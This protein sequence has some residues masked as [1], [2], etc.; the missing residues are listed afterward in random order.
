MIAQ[1]RQGFLG[2]KLTV[3]VDGCGYSC[4]S[5]LH[6]GILAQTQC[7]KSTHFACYRIGLAYHGLGPGQKP[8]GL[9]GPYKISTVGP[10]ET[11]VPGLPG[12]KVNGH[13]S[14]AVGPI[15]TIRLRLWAL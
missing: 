11:M 7:V 3:I 12:Q 9:P 4:M 10:L 14:A 13:S 8:S 6:A 1:Q 2:R 15:E 5:F